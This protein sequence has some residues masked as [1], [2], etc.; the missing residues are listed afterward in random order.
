MSLDAT[1]ISTPSLSLSLSPSLLL[2]PSLSLCLPPSIAPFPS[3]YIVSHSFS[4]A[5]SSVS[6]SSP[7]LAP[8][9]PYSLSLSALSHLLLLLSPT[10]LCDGA[11]IY[12][13]TGSI[14]LPWLLSS[15]FDSIRK[16]MSTCTIVYVVQ[17]CWLFML[18]IYY[19]YTFSLFV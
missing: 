18:I 16:I 19:N 17:Y 5:L 12:K 11:I 6:L 4:L 3:F 9:H 2:P 1:Q 13:P 14:I 15:K 8:I 7:S 10:G